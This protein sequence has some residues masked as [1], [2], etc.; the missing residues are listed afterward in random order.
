MRDLDTLRTSSNQ[1]VVYALYETVENVKSKLDSD[2]YCDLM[3]TVLVIRERLHLTSFM[4]EFET[5]VTSLD[6]E[7]APIRIGAGPM[8]S[9]ADRQERLIHALRIKHG[10][11]QDLVELRRT[12]REGRSTLSRAHENILKTIYQLERQQLLIEEHPIIL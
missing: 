4:D 9:E 6:R 5:E 12:F 3:N 11:E 1:D 2:A 8:R 10:I 7:H